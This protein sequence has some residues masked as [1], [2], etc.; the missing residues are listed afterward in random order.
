LTS[1]Y[2]ASRQREKAEKFRDQNRL[3]E[4]VK[5]YE[6][7]DALLDDPDIDAVYIP[8]PT[9]MHLEWVVKAANAH[10]HILIEKPV[11]IGK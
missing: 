5:I 6:G 4:N 11:A 1:Y 9:S 3:P 2:K 7:Y 10:K 8:L